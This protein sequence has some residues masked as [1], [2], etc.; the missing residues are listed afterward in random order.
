MIAQKLK[1]RLIELVDEDT[2]AFDSILLANRLP[3]KTS[4]Q[5]KY[6]E[7]KIIEAN[8]YA[9]EIPLET[10]KLS[11]EVVKLSTKLIKHGNPNSITDAEVAAEVGLAGVRGGCMNVMINL[12]AFENISRKYS[13]IK[14][15]IDAIIDEANQ[16]HQKAFKDT[17]RIIN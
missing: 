3:N 2:I 15:E 14:S 9:I 13:N 7:E 17:K 12:S 8:N 6:K 10:A 1:L 5:K 4:V 16:L 11:L